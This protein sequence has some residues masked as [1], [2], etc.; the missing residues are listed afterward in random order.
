LTNR[1][2]I[3]EI[4]QIFRAIDVNGDGVLS[5][6]ELASSLEFAG[7]ESDDLDFEEIFDQCDADCN[8][9]V[10]FHEFITSASD[11]K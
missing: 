11:R 1:E 3:A 9:T 10:D 6:H 2:E 4:T 7:I 8:G 5:R